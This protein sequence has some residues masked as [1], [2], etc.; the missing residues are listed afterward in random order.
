M[1]I[2][3]LRDIAAGEELT[4]HYN[5][6]WTGGREPVPCRCGAHT[7]VGFLGAGSKGFRKDVVEGLLAAADPAARVVRWEVDAA[8]QRFA[9]DCP[10]DDFASDEE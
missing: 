1:G 4:Y 6:D 9:V 7:C 2:F 3:A 10:A 5:F 8:G